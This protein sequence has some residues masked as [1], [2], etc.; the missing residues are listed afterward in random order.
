MKLVLL[1]AVLIGEAAAFGSLATKVSD[2]ALDEGDSTTD[3]T[4]GRGSLS[5]CADETCAQSESFTSDDLVLE[6]ILTYLAMTVLEEDSPCACDQA[7]VLLACALAACLQT[8]T[9]LFACPSHRLVLVAS[10]TL[11]IAAADDQFYCNLL[12]LPLDDTVAIGE[13]L[14]DAR[15]TT[16]LAALAENTCIVDMILDPTGAVLPLIAGSASFA[17]LA[18]AIAAGAGR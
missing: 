10:H 2:E 3:S 18:A 8:P 17:M 1:A 6:P 13:L 12:K 11:A 15:F 4:C 5:C 14:A 16:P 9:P 7:G